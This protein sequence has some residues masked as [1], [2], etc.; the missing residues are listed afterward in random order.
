MSIGV[1]IGTSAV[2]MVELRRSMRGFTLLGAARRNVALPAKPG[3]EAAAGARALKEAAPANGTPRPAWL[4]LTGRDL[5]LQLQ[6]YDRGL[7]NYRQLFEMEVNQRRDAGPE[8][9]VEGI[10]AHFPDLE[11]PQYLTIIGSAKAEWVEAR[12][13]A[14]RQAGLLPVDA[15]PNGTALFALYRHLVPEPPPD[16]S[17]LL[18]IGASNMELVLVRGRELLF[19][20]NVSSG[21]RIFEEHLHGNLGKSLADAEALKIRHGALGGGDDVDLVIAEELRPVLRVAANQLAGVIN[22]SFNYARTQLQDRTLKIGRIYLSGGGARLR[23][24]VEFLRGTM[25]MEVETLDPLAGLDLGRFGEEVPE[26]F[27]ELPS[28][29]AIATGLALLSAGAEGGPVLSLVP[30]PLKKKREFRRRTV[31]LILAAVAAG[32]LMSVMTAAALGEKMKVGDAAA[33]LEARVTADLGA[34]A[35]MEE[36]KAALGE[37]AAKTGR[38]R[39]FADPGRILLE[40]LSRLRRRMPKGLTLRDVKLRP[41]EEPPPPAFGG[42][43]E[44]LAPPGAMILDMSGELRANERD[45]AMA[46]LAEVA[47]WLGGEGIKSEVSQVVPRGDRPGWWRFAIT[48][49]FGGAAP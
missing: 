7:S 13:D 40:S 34:N 33:A 47:G 6:M 17:A 22:S 3:E 12:M 42:P 43:V 24:L 8:M 20:R 4:G 10:L 18:D 35:R 1:D 29:L 26:D 31:W 21:A 49:E 9:L 16:V 36:L 25:K 44:G 37:N 38:L 39:R 14:A 41:L 2:K 11:L 27:K 15:V 45:Q 32:L 5:H 30:A 46:A 48:V 23:G 19:M 28:D